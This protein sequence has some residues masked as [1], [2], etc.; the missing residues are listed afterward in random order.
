[1]RKEIS[2]LRIIN[3]KLIQMKKVY[4][5][6][7]LM[8]RFAAI[9]LFLFSSMFYFGCNKD[10]V[11]PEPVVANFSE[12]TVQSLE[13]AIDNVLIQNSVPGCVVGIWIP[14]EGT[15][16]TAR[17]D[18]DTET[19]EEMSTACAF[20][21]GSCTKM[22]VGIISLQ[23]VEEGLLNLNAPL[24]DYIDPFYIPDSDQVTILDLCRMTSGEL[25]FTF[26]P[27]FEAALLSDPYNTPN[28]IALTE[29]A[30]SLDTMIFEPGTSW[31]YSNTNTI[32]MQL[33]IEE[34]TGKS[35]QENIAERI[36]TPLGL[37]RTYWPETG[38][39][40]AP[41]SHGYLLLDP[42]GESIDCSDWPPV[43]AG[44][45]GQ[46]VSTAEDMKVFIEALGKG[47]LIS[48]EMQMVQE[49]GYEM[50]DGRAYGIYLGIDHGWLGHGGSI[51]GYTSTAYYLPE[52]DATIVVLANASITYD[53]HEAASVLFN[54]VAQIVTPE[55]IPYQSVQD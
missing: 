34:I 39:I 52:K 10:D 19:E 27:E 49:N 14:N 2:I 17:G 47:E 18:C 1:M 22:F 48:P 54:A 15:F 43:W 25:N 3:K 21:I 35:I 6:N 38:A 51:F 9:I 33:V 4:T 16:F 37:T 28:A 20:R 55:N 31:Q 50:G 42:S 30:C 46:L 7:N 36:T 5:K 41:Y 26:L 13:T 24:S 23:L 40:P 32:L 8:M 53:G 11:V 44:A 29:L 12:A 45:A